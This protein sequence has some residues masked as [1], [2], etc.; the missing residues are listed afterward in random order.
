MQDSLPEIHHGRE[1]IGYGVS[2][3]IYEFGPNTVLKIFHLPD[4]CE[5]SKKAVIPTV[6]R[7][8]NGASSRV[9]IVG[10]G[11]LLVVGRHHVVL[12]DI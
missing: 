1:L 10:G 2:G 6:R 12:L 11:F 7:A 4:N 5:F 9:G 8:F 3:F